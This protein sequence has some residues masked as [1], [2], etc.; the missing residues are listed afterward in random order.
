MPLT[1]GKYEILAKYEISAKTACLHT[2]NVC[3]DVAET[4]TPKLPKKT[5][6]SVRKFSQF[7]IIFF[8]SKNCGPKNKKNGT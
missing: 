8:L 3:D 1:M 5:A 4:V 7:I 6:K 2:C